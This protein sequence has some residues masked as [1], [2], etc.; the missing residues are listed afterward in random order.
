M[1]LVKNP[2]PNAINKGVAMQCT[3]QMDELIIPM[4]SALFIL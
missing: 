4:M 1:E 2:P 3:K